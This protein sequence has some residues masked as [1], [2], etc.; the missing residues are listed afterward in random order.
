MAD[1]DNYANA[2]VSI[3]EHRARKEEKAKLWTPR[4]AL[5]NTLRRIDAGDLEPVNLVMIVETDSHYE[6]VIATPDMDKTIALLW[7]GLKDEG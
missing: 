2:P 7:R 5:I 3:T 1:D 6:S 4:D